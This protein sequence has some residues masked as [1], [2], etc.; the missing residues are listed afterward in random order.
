MENLTKDVA[1][2]IKKLGKK[3]VKEHYMISLSS[4]MDSRNLNYLWWM[5]YKGNKKDN[6]TRPFIFASELN[7]QIYFGIISEEEKERLGNMITSV[8]EDNV[9]IAACAIEALRKQRIKIHGE[10]TED[11]SKISPTFLELVKTYRTSIIKNY[12]LDKI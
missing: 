1:S 12:S 4:S 2:K 7:L 9:Y 11:M 6:V 3:I 8:D 10:W 5:Y